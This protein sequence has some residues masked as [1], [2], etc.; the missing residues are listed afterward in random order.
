MHGEGNSNLKCV[1]FD[2]DDTL[3]EN[4]IPFSYVREGIKKYLLDIGI[5]ADSLWDAQQ[6]TYENVLNIANL[7]PALREKILGRFRELEIE[8]ARKSKLKDGA[9]QVLNELKIK[10]YKIALITRNCDDAVKIALGKIAEMFDLILTR[11]DC[12]YLKPDARQIMKGL[13]ILGVKPEECICV[14]DYDYDIIAARK[15]G[16]IAVRLGEGF[17]DFVIKDLRELLDILDGLR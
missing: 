3:V 10:G 11:D 16:C 13:A 9:L 5:D 14:G 15:C 1:I 2:M 4:A 12:E 6:P 17:G 8:R 7:Y